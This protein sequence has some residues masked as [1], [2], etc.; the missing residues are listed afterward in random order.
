[1]ELGE[2]SLLFG[3]DWRRLASAQNH[4]FHRVFH[5]GLTLGRLKENL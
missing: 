1:M 4:V 2:V 5:P 3:T